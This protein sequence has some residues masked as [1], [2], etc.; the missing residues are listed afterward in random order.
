MLSQLC[1]P[2]ETPDEPESILPTSPVVSPIQWTLDDRIAE[3]AA[4]EPALPSSNQIY[5][6]SSQRT[7]FIESIHSSVGTGKPG[8][9][10]T[11]PIIQE[12][13]WTPIMAIDFRNLP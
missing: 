6:P 9:N 12:Q 5:V 11:L 10:H 4:T 1:A 7:L 13:F 8:T 2:D 3:A